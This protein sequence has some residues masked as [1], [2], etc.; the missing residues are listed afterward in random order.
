MCGIWAVFGSDGDI[1]VQ[2]NAAHKITHRGP[3]AFRLE[4]MNHFPG[5]CLG[6]HRLAIV[7]DLQGMQPM[8]IFQHPHIWVLYNGEIYNHDL[9]T[10]RKILF[11]LFEM[12][13]LLNS[14]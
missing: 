8:R 5:C 10:I 12:L 4:S 1:S 14:K 6:F 13:P 7:D 9:V 11:K 3:D 2:C